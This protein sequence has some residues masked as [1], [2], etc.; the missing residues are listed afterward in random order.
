DRIP[1]VA[2]TAHAMGDYKN[3]CLEA[4]MDDYLSK[5]LLRKDLLAMVDKWTSQD[6]EYKTLDSISNDKKIITQPEQLPADQS[7]TSDTDEPMNYDK[8]LEEFMGKQDLLTKVL[9][10]FLEN[11][12]DQIK[13]LQK[14]IIDKDSEVIRTQAHTIKG[15]ASN[16][17]AKKL[18]EIAFELEKIG[19]SGELKEADN[20]MNKFE[21]EFSRLEVYLEDRQV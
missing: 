6:T 3:L 16:L 5:P 7:Q 12:R 21:K 11:A 20:L 9:N 19:T 18:S 14:A 4:G 1:I 17:T 8:A 10:T 13:I 2:M 15:G